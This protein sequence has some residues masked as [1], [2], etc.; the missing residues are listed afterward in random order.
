MTH[1][2]EGMVKTPQTPWDPRQSEVRDD[3]NDEKT[4]EIPDEIGENWVKL[5][6]KI[7][8]RMRMFG[9]KEDGPD[10]RQDGWRKN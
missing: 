10:L 8:T 3:L 4:T 5:K 7:W 9:R 2:H 6:R 1:E